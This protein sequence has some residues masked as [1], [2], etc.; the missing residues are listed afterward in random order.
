MIFITGTDTGVGK[1]HFSCL[2]IR[3][4]RATGVSAVGFKPIC[5]GD[6]D[7]AVQLA[8]ASDDALTINACNPV[9]MRFPASPYTSSIIEERPIDLGQIRMD[10]EALRGRF[11]AVIVEGVGGW[12]VPIHRDYNT[13]DLARELGLPVLLI[14]AN[15]LG[16]LNH[17]LLT[18]HAIQS[19]GLTCAGIILNNLAPICP[20][21]PTCLT[22]QSVLED[23]LHGTPVPVL[24]EIETG[25][26]VLPKAIFEKIHPLF[27]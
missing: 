8:K 7:D 3:Q 24:G 16:V 20:D 27:L 17:T 10:W 18:L 12:Q 23:L 5:C 15:R 1:T 26:S 19:A 21:D 2:L 25:Q 9:W 4:L 6:R 11:P 14:A 13:G 22:N